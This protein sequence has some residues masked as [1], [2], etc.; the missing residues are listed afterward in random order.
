MTLQLCQ[1]IAL[2]LAAVPTNLYI[3]NTDPFQS[4]PFSS[5][6][7]HYNYN[8]QHTCAAALV[9]LKDNDYNM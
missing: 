3:E 1:R 5:T 8:N 4:V 7:C 2:M 9:D 6:A